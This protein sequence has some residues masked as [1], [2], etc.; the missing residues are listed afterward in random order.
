MIKKEFIR[1]FEG[2]TPELVLNPTAIYQIA[3]DLAFKGNN[4]VWHLSSYNLQSQY[5]PRILTCGRVP[6][7]SDTIILDFPVGTILPYPIYLTSTNFAIAD[8]DG[9]QSNDTDKQY[10]IGTTYDLN[11]SKTKYTK[12]FLEFRVAE[13]YAQ[14]GQVFYIFIKSNVSTIDS[15]YKAYDYLFSFNLPPLVSGWISLE[16]TD[17]TFKGLLFSST[18]LQLEL[19]KN[20]IL[21]NQISSLEIIEVTNVLTDYQLR[22][23][24]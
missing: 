8:A 1:L 9:S 2:A 23:V 15:F 3:D 21:N 12:V 24:P 14:V 13:I 6:D 10:F 16:I 20:V 5:S 18:T 17:P 22:Y 11:F 7:N 4:T 19:G